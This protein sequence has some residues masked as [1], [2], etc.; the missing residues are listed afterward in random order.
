MYTSSF[1]Y[2][3][4]VAICQNAIKSLNSL[5][6]K[7]RYKRNSV[8]CLNFLKYGMKTKKLRNFEFVCTFFKQIK[9]KL[10]FNILI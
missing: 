2:I 8:I 9:V 3:C 1:F 10:Y 6:F 4:L 7:L 5:H